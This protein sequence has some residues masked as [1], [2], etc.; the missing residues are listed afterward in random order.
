[1]VLGQL[2]RSWI[3]TETFRLCFFIGLLLLGTH[4]V[5]RGLL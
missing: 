5:L 2:V 3:K 1:M 4:L